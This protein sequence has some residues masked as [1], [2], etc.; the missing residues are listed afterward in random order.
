ME[1][2][3]G[4]KKLKIAVF[5][6]SGIQE[7][8]GFQYESMVLNIIKKYHENV[9]IVFEY[10][11]LNKKILKDYKHLNIPINEIS[12]NFFQKMHRISLSNLYLYRLYKKIHL[13]HSSIEKK[14]Q[15]D[16]IDLVYFLYPSN[17]GQTLVSMSYVYTLWDLGHLELIE[18]PEMS[19]DKKFEK[20]ERNFIYSLKKAFKV[21]VDGD[22]GKKN[23]V[24]RYNLDAR[25]VE[26]LKFLP[27]IRVTSGDKY[28][29]IKDKYNISGD[30][31]FYPA[32]FWAHK[33]HTYIL[34]AIKIL[35]DENNIKINVIFSG[36][37]KGNLNHILKLSREYGVDSLV[38]YIG[39]VPDNEIPYL[40]KQSLSLVMPSLLGPTNIPP[41]EAF[42]YGTPV[43]YSDTPFFREQVGDAVFYCDLSSPSSLVKHL[44]C[45]M[46]NNDLVKTKKTQGKLILENWNE[47][48]FYN[49]LLFIFKEYKVIRE[50]WN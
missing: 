42:Y 24:S 21:I 4:S 23:V 26:I 2:C 31:I 22:Y 27:N 28:V 44:I 49:K 45:I 10:Y 41:L 25:R 40:Y 46:S 15:K 6:S 35:K 17:I 9:D 34:K 29:D 20:R 32:Q 33:N 39:F 37:D 1:C 7:G 30:Y 13:N 5:I 8:G 48:D 50:K 11:T 43:C 18:F 12:E 14:L 47:V 3:M 16:S 38:H 36:S 19:Y